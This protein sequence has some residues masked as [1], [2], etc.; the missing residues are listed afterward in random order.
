MN[1][2]SPHETQPD[3]PARRVSWWDDHGEMHPFDD[4]GPDLLLALKL[5]EGSHLSAIYLQDY[6]WSLS[7]H[8][9]Q[10][11]CMSFDDAG[12]FLNAVW[13][14]KLGLGTYLRFQVSGTGVLQVR[15]CKHRGACVSV[16]GV[17]VDSIF[18]PTVIKSEG[19]EL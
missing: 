11:S 18:R 6:D 5:P 12:H 1:D 13:S 15:F 8:P 16:G 2:G 14:G 7:R 17:F 3:F 19:A 9:R 10:Q 4:E